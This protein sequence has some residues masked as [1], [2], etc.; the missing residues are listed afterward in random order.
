[1]NSLIFFVLVGLS[2]LA[3]CAPPAVDECSGKSTQCPNPDGPDS[4]YIPLE[5]CTKFC[6]CSNGQAILHHCPGI[7]HF[8]PVL[9]VCDY[10]QDAGC[11]KSGNTTTSVATTTKPSPTPL[12]VTTPGGDKCVDVLPCDPEC[13]SGKTVVALE[14]C[15]EAC[16]CSNGIL[17][18]ITCSEGLHYNVKEEKCDFPNLANCEPGNI[19]TII[20]TTTTSVPIT[21][22]TTTTT[23]KPLDECSEKSAQCPNPDG[24]DSVY[25]PLDD[26]T[27][28][29]QCSNG[30]AILH[31]CPDGLHFNPVLNVCDWPQDAGCGNT[32][33][34]SASTTSA[35]TTSASTTSAS[36]TTTSA[37][38]TTPSTTTTLRPVD[39]C[40]DKSAQC[41]NPDGPDSVYI[42]LD[43]CTKFCQCS[44][45]QAILHNCPEGLHFNPVL[46]VCDWPQ[47]AGCGNT[48]TTSAST[49]SAPTTTTSAPVTTPSTT[50]TLRPVDECTEKSAQCP[51]PDGPDS[52]YIP[53]DD[54]TKFCQCSNGQAILH[55]CPDG[56]HFNPVLNVCDW[57]QDAGCGNTTTT[58]ASTTSASTTTTSAPVTTPS[59]TTTLRPVDE[60]TDKSAQCPNPDGPD[61]VYIPLDDCT[62]FCQCSNGQAILHNCPDGL[63]FNPV[64]N[65]C[66]WPQDAGCGNTTTTSASTTTTSAPVTTPSTTTTLRPVDECTDKSAQC[67]N[68]DG[69]DSVY[70]PLDDCT[71][72]CQCSNGQAILHNC[73]EGL[74]FNP[75]LNVCDWPQDAGCGNT[76]TTSASTTSASTTT[77]SAPVTTP[78]TTTTLRPV[79]ECTDKSAQCPNPDGSDSVYIPLDDCTKFC[80]CSNGQAILHNCPEGLHFNPVLNVCDWPQ[81][82]G[83]GNTT[84]TSAS[85]TSAST[86]TTSAPVTTPS[87]TTTL[88]PVDECTDKSAQCPNPDGS[89]SVYIPLDDC[90]KFCQCS[91]GQAIL[92][93]CP[94]GLH[95]NPVL[96]V[97]D[98]PQDAGCGNTTTTSA[99]T[100]SASTTTTSAPVTT[101]STTTTLRPVDECTEKSAQCP[102]PDGPD[103]VYIPLDDC[104]KFCQCSNGQAILHNCPDGLHFN[105]VL[106]VCDWPQDAGCG[107]ATTTSAST[108]SA[109]TTTT[110]A[111]VT[112]PS[113][114]TT[115]RPVDECTD[116]SAQCPNPDG[117]DSVYIPLDDCTK[118]CQCSNGQA[119]LHNCPDGLHFNPVLNVCD[120]PQDAGCGNTTTT[121]AS[122]TSA[123]TT[124]TS[125]PVTTPSTTTTLRPVDE[126]TDKSAQCPNPDG[127]DSVYIP[128]DDC[129]KFC[130]CSNGQ[131]ILHNCPEGLH[132]NPVL[133][134]CDWPQDAGCGNTTTTSASTTSASTTTTSAPVTT[135]STT[136]TLRPVD[137]CTEKSAQCPNPDGPDSVYI[138]LDDCTKFCQCSNGQAILHNCPDGLHF[139]PVLNV[140]D[141]PQD[142]G[143]GNTTTT[144]AST[145]S[146]STTSAST[147][148]TSAPV[149][150]PSTPTTLRPVD[151]CTDKS[152]QCPNPDGPDS[153][154]I[155]L[156]DCTKFCQCSNGQAIL[157]NCPDGLHFNPVLN[158]CDWPQ[159]AGCGNTTTTSASTTSTS[160]TSASTTTT[161]APVTTPST[162]TTL[163]PVDECTD[164]SAQCPN[165]DGPDSVYIP[166]D[167]CTK[168][169]QCSNGQAILHNCP[170]GLHFNPVL[171][172]CDWP[173]DA[174]CGNTTT[175][176]ASTTSASTT[177]TSAP[178]TTPSTTT[179]LRPVDEC[180]EKSAQC[181]N[182]D[183]PD[184]VYIPLDDCTK[185]CQC[186]NG[187]AIL[188]NCPD[189]LH[190][191]P[192]L[193]VCDWP[194]D[195][196][197]GN[198]TTTSASTTSAST[199]T[200]SAPVTTPSTTTTLRPVDE[201]T[202]KSAQCPNPDGPDSV[203]IPLDDCTKFCQC[204]NGQ[205]I[206]HNCPDG[207]HFN[208]V[209]NVC[210]WPQDAGC[211]NTT[212]TS[213]STTSASTTTTSAPVTT[214]STTT[215]LRPVDECTDKSAQC[216]NPDGPDSV[217]IPLDDCTKFCQCS[218]GQAILHNCPDGLHFNPVLNVCDWPQDAGCGNT[219]TTSASTTSASTTT[220]SAPVTTP[221]TTTTLRPVDECTD[222][223]AQCPNPDGPDSVYIPLDD[224]T[225]FCQCSNG[226]AI[227]HNCP[228]GLHFNPVLNVCDWPQDAGCGNT[229]TTSASTTSASTTTTSAP[230]TTPSTT[231]TLRPIDECT[232]KSA[233]CPNPDGPDS[234]YIPLDDCTKFCQCSNGQAILHNCPDGLHFNPVLNVCDWPQDAGCGNTT[235]TSASTTSA[236]TTTTSAPVTTPSTTTTLRPVDECTD[237]SAQCPNPDG[238]DSVYIP[239]DDCTKFCQCSNGQAILHNCPDGLHFN[240]VLN[241]CDWPQDAGCGK[242]VNTTTTSTTTTSA[243][244]TTTTSISTTTTVPSRAVCLGQEKHCP[245]VDGEFPVYIP[246]PTCTKFC[247]CSNGIPYEFDCPANLHFNPELN[248]CDY[249]ERAGCTGLGI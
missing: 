72:F 107:N 178:V 144:S 164:K 246:L 38:V 120:W 236:S 212:T 39:E 41:P 51:N 27:K 122:T 55:N 183:G 217:Y 22:P 165:P 172:V 114:T 17:N 80:Q 67:P 24:P 20:P 109:S 168:F 49:T 25:I 100:T 150:T 56:L 185:F 123:S 63:H 184:S 177:T 106:N 137:E 3:S 163:R 14:D 173:Q 48:T 54:C 203:Y 189:G 190:F 75:V 26:C 202:E 131:A 140:C 93:N 132:F 195:A 155:P 37:P 31:N 162:T 237:K 118:F 221:S 141:W 32:T 220:T 103:S 139:N 148:T 1:M 225:K 179:T 154:Y 233:Q 16:E 97:C 5:D 66:D 136:T 208:P 130:Q 214:P 92:H 23:K 135:P 2:G 79:D 11:E 85:T 101:P 83:C 34:T 33:T 142:A 57:P 12:P 248:V 138:P 234:V 182:P 52:V 194:Q 180:T 145:T 117:P 6:Q 15:S 104:T 161:S 88:R 157:H 43:D 227:L 46:N 28:F 239:L 209:L 36:T 224:C 213:A 96:N 240:P 166:L 187:Q 60:C 110:S 231:T 19:T 244:V 175:T 98:W 226:E 127:P 245:A 121:S 199:T 170:E 129:T 188:H 249:P 71:K 70:I 218:N 149:T 112:T 198:T 201:C 241:V 90:T 10:P 181:P 215:T 206:L 45:G 228:D 99:S 116:K 108:T 229:T 40:T 146:A 69:P 58:S 216:P 128:L 86:T 111:P 119:I 219:T 73:P 230:V 191:N 125:A 87:T 242:Q 64:L 74:H 192:V 232:D 89:D 29:C 91:N 4:V 204:S 124:T 167:D 151:E 176:S 171:N 65:V 210:D 133:N 53:L 30:Q 152:A 147:T 235:T 84:T 169:C 186:S 81:D 205:A 193:N 47:D 126:C 8:N 223:S 62:K 35:S 9:N 238:P 102:N 207:L 68:P 21:T 159:D 134:V 7:L 105:P 243:P 115:L 18:L 211:G 94:E 196:G 247:E 197:C 50:T 42:P 158:V 153:V 95:F 44:N 78:S 13:G 61:S 77:T 82:A 200:T 113:T 143:C 59:T 222:K 174:G 160:T 156:D 76:T